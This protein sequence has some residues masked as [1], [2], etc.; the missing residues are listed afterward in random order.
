MKRLALFLAWV[1]AIAALGWYVQRTL[2]VGADLR[3][4]MPTPVTD[5]QRLLVDEI[6]EGPGSRLTSAEQSP[7]DVP[8]DHDRHDEGDIGAELQCNEHQLH[9]VPPQFDSTV[10]TGYGS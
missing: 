7:N 4:F 6:G 9:P 5:A 1:A 2:V 8:D 3:L 10:I